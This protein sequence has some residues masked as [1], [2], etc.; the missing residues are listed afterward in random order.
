MPAFGQI[1]SADD[2]ALIAQYLRG[3]DLT[4]LGDEEVGP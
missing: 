3:V 1:L 4:G 2:I